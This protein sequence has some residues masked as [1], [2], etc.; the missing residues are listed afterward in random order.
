MIFISIPSYRDEELEKTVRSL[1]QN[2]THPKNLRFGIVNQDARGKHA[3]FSWLGNQARVH[4]MHYKDA[5]GAGYARKLAMELYNGEA[6]YL[7]VD[8]HMRFVQ[9]W[10]TKFI[11]MY[12]WC[13]TDAGTDKVILSQFPAPY[14]A[15]TDGKDYPITGDKDFWDRPAWTT[16][17]N[18]WAG[19]WAGNREE[20]EDKSHPHPTHTIL[21]GLLFTHG[22]IVKNIPYDDR[23]AFMGEELCFAIRAYT[24]GY[25]LYA[26]NEMLATHFYKRDERP[27]IWRDNVAGRSWTDLEMHSQQ[28][29]KRVLLGADEGVYGI[30]DY[31]KYLDYQDMIGINFE[32]FYA[33]EIDKKT[34]LGLI[35]TETIFDD[36]FNM[37]EIARSGY[38]SNGLH[39]QCLAYDHCDCQCHEG[40][41]NERQR[42]APTE[43]L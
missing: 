32:T 17:V 6:F 11:D 4:N 40:V 8:S 41:R 22:D 2:A 42:R 33:E 25:A 18:T 5:K 38:C 28:V 43:R 12:D 9:G 19:V 14:L 20:I 39:S 31:Q 21:A 15:G 24:R 36:E 29:Q 10:D 16:V 26:P 1:Y 35:T 37:V 27:K 34:N 30:G 23:I 7:Q 3:D 13:V